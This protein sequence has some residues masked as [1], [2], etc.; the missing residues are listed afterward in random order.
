MSVCQ[1]SSY[2]SRCYHRAGQPKR[3]AKVPYEAA[4]AQGIGPDLPRKISLNC[5]RRGE[6]GEDF[7]RKFPGKLPVSREFEGR[8]RLAADCALSEGGSIP[9]I[10]CSLMLE[11]QRS[12]APSPSASSRG[13]DW[14]LHIMLAV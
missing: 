14:R 8:N 11:R 5:R 3:G 6:Q 4:A 9:R 2:C 12:L 7:P 13:F 1:T 10:I